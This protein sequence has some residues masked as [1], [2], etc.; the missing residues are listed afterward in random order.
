MGIQLLNVGFGHI[1]YLLIVLWLL[2]SPEICTKWLL[3]FQDAR[4]KGLL[5]DA[6]YGRK[7]RAM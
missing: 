2:S 6:T 4:G 7:T 5:I 1:W 3:R